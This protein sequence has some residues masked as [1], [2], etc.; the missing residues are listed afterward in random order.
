MHQNGNEAQQQPRTVKLLNSD[1]GACV[2]PA[3]N[4]NYYAKDGGTKEVE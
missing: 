4:G 1:A 2:R 3:C